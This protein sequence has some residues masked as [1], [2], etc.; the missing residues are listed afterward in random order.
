MELEDL[1][2]GDMFFGTTWIGMGQAVADS[3]PPTKIFLISCSFLEKSGKFVCWRPLLQ[4][5]RPPPMRNPG[6]TPDK[7]S[8]IQ[9]FLIL[10]RIERY[11]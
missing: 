1:D 6:S 2:N 7:C 4:G 5:W 10:R 9:I 11:S 3:P 8:S